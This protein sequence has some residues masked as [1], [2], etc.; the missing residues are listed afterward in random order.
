MDFKHSMP[1]ATHLFEEKSRNCCSKIL[2]NESNDNSEKNNQNV[3]VFSL[4]QYY[5]ARDIGLQNSGYVDK[6]FDTGQEFIIALEYEYGVRISVITVSSKFACEVLEHAVGNHLRRQNKWTKLSSPAYFVCNIL[7][8]T[9]K[10][11]SSTNYSTMQH[12]HLKI[13]VVP[14]RFSSSYSSA[15][16]VDKQRNS[17][18]EDIGSNCADIIELEK[19]RQWNGHQPIPSEKFTSLLVMLVVRSILPV[20][21]N[22]RYHR[23]RYHGRDKY[24]D[25]TTKLCE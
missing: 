11:L 8:K 13:L 24:I 7:T 19:A 15:T 1:N 17:Q 2:A 12:Y 9:L 10:R 18:L 6:W 4:K 5:E 3:E 22:E 23:T 16:Y 21:F 20:I 25:M 14:W